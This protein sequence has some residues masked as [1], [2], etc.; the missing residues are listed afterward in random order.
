MRG[1]IFDDNYVIEKEDFLEYILNAN[2]EVFERKN[3]ILNNLKDKVQRTELKEI[4]LATNDRDLLRLTIE[5]LPLKFSRR[6]GDPSRPWNYF[7]IN[8]RDET[9]G[10]KIL[11]YEG[12]WRDLFQNWEALAHSYP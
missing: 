10:K 4:V 8:T 6:H 12:N 5:Y 7:T 1:G 2:K 11:D 9:T 3:T